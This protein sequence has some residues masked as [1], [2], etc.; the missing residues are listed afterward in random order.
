M[1]VAVFTFR[2]FEERYGRTYKTPTITYP[3][4]TVFEGNVSAVSAP[5]S[6]RPLCS[7]WV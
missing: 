2:I 5:L 7:V 6:C 4:D 3:D 1:N